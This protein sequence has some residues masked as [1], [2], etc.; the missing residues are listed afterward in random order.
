MNTTNGLRST[1][2][3]KVI[4]IT[5]K[6]HFRFRRKKWLLCQKLNEKVHTLAGVGEWSERVDEDLRELL[7]VTLELYKMS[8]W[9]ETSPTKGLIPDKLY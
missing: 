9:D 6:M 4:P 3:I 1:A 5:D 8:E 2:T 7:E